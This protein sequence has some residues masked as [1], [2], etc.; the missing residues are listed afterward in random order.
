VERRRHTTR[1]E[2]RRKK[3]RSGAKARK[4]RSETNIYYIMYA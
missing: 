2:R 3:E 4:E 1:S